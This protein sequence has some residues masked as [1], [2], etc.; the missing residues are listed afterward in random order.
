MKI[1]KKPT[2]LLFNK[3]FI[4]L[5]LITL[6]AVAAISTV[7]Q[8][9]QTQQHAAMPVNINTAN[10]IESTIN[11]DGSMGPKSAKDN[12]STT[13]LH[14]YLG[15]VTINLNDSQQEEKNNKD[16]QKISSIKL[17]LAKA[18]THLIYLFLPG[19]TIDNE[20][21]MENK[22][23]TG[24]RTNQNLD[25]WEVINLNKDTTEPTLEL[26]A[27]ESTLLATTDLGGGKYSEIRIYIKSATVKFSDGKEMPLTIPG[28]SNII[29]I[30]HPFNIYPEKTTLLTLN[31]SLQQSIV[32]T[33]NTYF[34]QPALYSLTALNQ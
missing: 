23:N 31:M 14:P 3:N 21:N 25:K 30:V 1:T 33:G 16:T 27:G 12:F 29:R 10:E 9:T 24:Q 17:T 6:S 20:K 5:T 19:T 2:Y 26:K 4:I 7:T 34:L 32:Q 22:N 8:K 18:E 11:T 28:R 15:K 13:L